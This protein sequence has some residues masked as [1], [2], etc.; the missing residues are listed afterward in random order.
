MTGLYRIG[1]DEADRDPR[2]YGFASTMLPYR[3][4]N[5]T[6]QRRLGGRHSA[7]VVLYSVDYREIKRR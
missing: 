2:R 6:V 5:E 4:L 1:F 7:R 3:L